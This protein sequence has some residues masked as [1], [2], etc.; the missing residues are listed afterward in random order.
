M[1]RSEGVMKYAIA[2]FCAI[3][4]VALAHDSTVLDEATDLVQEEAMVDL[5]AKT[6][7][8]V[9][10]HEAASAK[11]AAKAGSKAKARATVM[12]GTHELDAEA[13]QMAKH[14]LSKVS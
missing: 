14:Q 3:A 7:A 11:V 4:V 13:V 5:S 2:I 9:S 1:G 8:K 6:Q 12:I 10:V